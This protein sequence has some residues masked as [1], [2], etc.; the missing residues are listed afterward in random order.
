MQSVWQ[1][2]FKKNLYNGIYYFIV[3]TQSNAGVDWEI[4]SAQ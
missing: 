1:L 3:Q 4:L 2:Y